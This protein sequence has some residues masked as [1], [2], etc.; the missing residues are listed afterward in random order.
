MG[1]SAS[2][3]GSNLAPLRSV[4]NRLSKTG[5]ALGIV[6]AAPLLGSSCRTNFLHDWIFPPPSPRIRRAM[7]V[8]GL[9]AQG[10]GPLFASRWIEPAGRAHRLEP[11]GEE[12]APAVSAVSEI[13]RFAAHVGSTVTTALLGVDAGTAIE[14]VAAIVGNLPAVGPRVSARPRSAVGRTMTAIEQ[15]ATAV[16]HRAARHAQ[17]LAS[18]RGT[19]RSATLVKRTA[20]PT[21]LG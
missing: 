5:Q 11:R 21:G 14:Q 6:V 8:A 19:V 4:G 18:E 16:A 1:L 10:G 9:I 2:S 12:N 17:R 15:I 20:A 13:G 7:G 3:S